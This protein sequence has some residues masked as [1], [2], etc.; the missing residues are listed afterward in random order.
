MSHSLTTTQHGLVTLVSRSRFGRQGGHRD[1]RQYRNRLRNRQGFRQDGSSRHFGVPIGGKSDR[2]RCFDRPLLAR[3]R[4]QRA[5][6]PRS[7]GDRENAKRT[8]RSEARV[9]RRYQRRIHSTRFVFARV[10]T[11]LRQGLLGATSSA[12]SARSQCRNRN[13][14][15]LT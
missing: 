14:Q 1:G 13:D 2:G 12:S 3:S 4:V 15:S 10:G 9:G 11:R 7:A 6:T 5:R 8:G